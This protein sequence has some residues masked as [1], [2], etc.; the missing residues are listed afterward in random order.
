LGRARWLVCCEPLLRRAHDEGGVAPH[1][2]NNKTPFSVHTSAPPLHYAT[3]AVVPVFMFFFFFFSF[4]F[5]FEGRAQVIPIARRLE[6]L[7]RNENTYISFY[8]GR[9]RTGA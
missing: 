3:K 6:T 1:S 8:Q 2:F 4:C 9:R 5:V 7:T